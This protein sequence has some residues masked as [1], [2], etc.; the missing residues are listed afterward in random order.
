[1]CVIAVS[2]KGADIPTKEQLTKMW[3]ANPDGAGYAYIGRGG[4]VHYR[5]GFMKLEDLLKELEHPERFKRTLFAIHFRIGTSGENDA[6]T[7]HPFPVT[8]NF[9]ELTKSEGTAD[10][11]LF[12]N[13][14]LDKGG[15]C[16]PL[17]SD[18]QDFVV[19]M[20]PLIH[21]HFKSKVRDHIIASMTQG[22]RLFIMYKGGKTKMYGTWSKDGDL[23][24]SN[25]YYQEYY[26]TYYGHNYGHNYG[27]Y[28]SYDDKALAAQRSKEFWDDF[29][30]GYADTT[31]TKTKTTTTTSRLT[32]EDSN[33]ADRLWAR[34]LTR[35]YAYV[36]DPELALLKRT[37]DD[38]TPHQLTYGGLVFG[39]N[40]ADNLVWY[41]E[42]Q[43]FIQ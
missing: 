42:E 25:T 33:K 38:Y 27:A 35:S 37:S 30:S 21:K 3:N 26:D 39:Y 36:T 18:T 16:N 2:P 17:A 34:I 29:Y 41:E 4:R 19:G 31:K 9:G 22:N 5:K 13:G 15:V 14:V 12:H 28:T 6:K 40:Q 24:V 8:T 23:W 7:C 32:D 43:E 11:V 20:A 1:M 10:S